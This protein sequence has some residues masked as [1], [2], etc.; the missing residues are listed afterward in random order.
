MEAIKLDRR[1]FESTRGQIVTILRA[2][3]NQLIDVLKN[4][5]MPSEIED[6]LREVGRAIA[7]GTPGGR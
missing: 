7:A 4:R 1:F 5:L 6:V 3:L 2:S